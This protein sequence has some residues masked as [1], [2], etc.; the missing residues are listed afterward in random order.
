MQL[1]SCSCNHPAGGSALG[2]AACPG[3]KKGPNI[4]QNQPPGPDLRLTR[5]SAHRSPPAAAALPAACWWRAASVPLHPAGRRAAPP[6]RVQAGS[7]R[8]PAEAH[9]LLSPAGA[10]QTLLLAAHRAGRQDRTSEGRGPGGGSTCMRVEPGCEA[11]AQQQSRRGAFLPAANHPS[12]RPCSRERMPGRAAQAGRP[13]RSGPAR[14]PPPV[15]T[16]RSASSSASPAPASRSSSPNACG[17]AP[18]AGS[19]SCVPTVQGSTGA[20]LRTGLQTPAIELPGPQTCWTYAVSRAL[21]VAPS[22][23]GRVA[24]RPSSW[25]CRGACLRAPPGSPYCPRY[26][27][28]SGAPWRRVSRPRAAAVPPRTATTAAVHGRQQPAAGVGRGKH[29]RADTSQL[30]TA[31]APAQVARRCS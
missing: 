15:S 18:G 4:A 19:G 1:A 21:F 12:A 3:W 23:F 8:L 28:A 25:C 29:W 6:L 13:L 2:K 30:C 20:R 24:G 27:P 11:R 17:G 10:R 9:E 26:P 22:C 7:A 31:A 14:A 5:P 16:L